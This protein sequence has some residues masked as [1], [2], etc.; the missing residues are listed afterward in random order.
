MASRGAQTSRLAFAL[1]K[2]GKF[3]RIRKPYQSQPDRS[4]TAILGRIG[5]RAV[6]ISNLVEEL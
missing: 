1:R 5:V 4:Q 6:G 2:F 3:H